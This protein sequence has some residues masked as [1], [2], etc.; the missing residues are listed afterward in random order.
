MAVMRWLA[1]VESTIAGCTAANPAFDLLDGDDD[2]AMSLDG[3]DDA[4]G[5]STEDGE[6]S[7]TGSIDG[8]GPF[9]PPAEVELTV[10][11]ARICG[12]YVVTGTVEAIT[13]NEIHM[14]CDS[15]FDS[16]CLPDALAVLRID[17]GLPPELDVA[18]DRAMQLHWNTTDDDRCEF[19]VVRL[20]AGDELRETFVALGAPGIFQASLNAYNVEAQMLEACEC[21]DCCT[22]QQGQYELVKQL[23]DGQS[24]ALAEGEEADGLDE[25]LRYRFRNIAANVTGTCRKA[26]HWQAVRI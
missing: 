14:R 25:G 9:A 5:G 24:L 6:G 2:S 19:G 18:P 3:Q 22:L 13:D 10:D 23:D 16:D 20:Q 1:M 15:E 4:A 21:S 7:E 26:F 8:C 11:G 17:H 12:L